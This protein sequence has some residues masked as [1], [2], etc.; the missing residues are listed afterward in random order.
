MMGIFDQAIRTQG[1][2]AFAK[3][4][5]IPAG[6]MFPAMPNPQG[7]NGFTG[8]SVALFNEQTKAVRDLFG[9]SDKP[10]NVKIANLNI[11]VIGAATE[12][13]S[14]NTGQAFTGNFPVVQ[15]GNEVVNTI[16]PKDPSRTRNY[17]RAKI[18]VDDNTAFD[19]N[20]KQSFW[21][22]DGS[23]SHFQGRHKQLE[24]GLWNDVDEYEVLIP[25]PNSGLSSYRLDKM[26]APNKEAAPYI[27]QG[28]NAGRGG[29][30]SNFADKY[31][32][33]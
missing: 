2:G 14:P 19:Q 5:Q 12:V 31:T 3:Q 28:I 9:F 22:V 6:T 1:S 16:D 23:T 10:K 20:M 17:I 15:M 11:P 21:V 32:K 29:T 25:L 13:V 7:G 24:G 8:M 27:M 33:K 26:V 4:E 18:A 30:V